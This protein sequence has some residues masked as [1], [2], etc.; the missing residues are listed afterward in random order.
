MSTA[1]RVNGVGWVEMDGTGE[2][3][4]EGLVMDFSSW[5]I[6]KLSLRS[7]ARV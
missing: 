1:G 4:E 2:G 5:S 6:N 3:L 7:F